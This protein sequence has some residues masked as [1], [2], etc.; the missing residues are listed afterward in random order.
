[1]NLAEVVNRRSVA[2]RA[3]LIL[4]SRRPLPFQPFTRPLLRRRHARFLRPRRPLRRSHR[5]QAPLAADLASLAA[6]LAHCL[7]KKFLAQ[8]SEIL[9]GLG[10]ILQCALIT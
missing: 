7:T 4:L 8:H 2:Q 3:A 6:H 5:F 10:V 1:M 9:T